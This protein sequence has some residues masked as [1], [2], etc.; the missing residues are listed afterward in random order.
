[1][2]KD[3]KTLKST[4]GLQLAPFKQLYSR[5]ESKLAS[6]DL[7]GEELTRQTKE[8]SLDAIGELL[9]FLFY[10]RHYCTERVCAWLFEISQSQVNKYIRH[11]RVIM[12]NYYKNTITPSIYYKRVADSKVL[13]TWMVTIVIDGVEQQIKIPR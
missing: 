10:V 7:D 5:F 2:L 3:E 4:T 13:R 9:L 12:H 11:V 6:T 1:M 8:R